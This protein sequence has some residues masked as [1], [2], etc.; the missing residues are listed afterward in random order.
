MIV[1]CRS[2]GRPDAECLPRGLLPV[3]VTALSL[4]EDYSTDSGARNRENADPERMFWV[5]NRLAAADL[6][7]I[8]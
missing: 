6:T 4:L 5:T 3:A 1:S 8:K 2:R 7:W